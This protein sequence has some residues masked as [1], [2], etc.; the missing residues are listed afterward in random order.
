MSKSD[1][2]TRPV[3]RVAPW[4]ERAA[5]EILEFLAGPGVTEILDNDVEEWAKIIARHDPAM[6]DTEASDV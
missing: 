1:D 4:H 2:K 5:E 6:A 3:A